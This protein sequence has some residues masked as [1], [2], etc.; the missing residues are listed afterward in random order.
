MHAGA[1]ACLALATVRGREIVAS[2]QACLG[3]KPGVDDAQQVRQVCQDASPR[4]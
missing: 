2:R 4:H 1:G 3:A